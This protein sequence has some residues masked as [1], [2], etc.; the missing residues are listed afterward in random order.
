[1]DITTLLVL[2][3]AVVVVGIGAVDESRRGHADPRQEHRS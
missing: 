3:V 1:M 2:L